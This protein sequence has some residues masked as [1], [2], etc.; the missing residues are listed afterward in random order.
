MLVFPVLGL[1]YAWTDNTTNQEV[2]RL[3]TTVDES[4]PFIKYFSIPYS[5][6]IFY[7]YVCI[8][9]FF[10]KDANVYYRAISTYILCALLCYL[11]YSVFQTTV[12]RPVVMGSD[13]FS[14]LMRYIYHRD[15]PFNCFPSIHCFSS[16]LVMRTI[17]TSSFRNKWNLTIITTMSSTI[18]MSTLFVKQHVIM[19]ALA[20]ILLVEIVTA[21][22][23]LLEQR[24][25][26]IRHERGKGSLG[27]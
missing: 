3:V 26:I 1:M 2:Y 11:I 20:G 10:K 19:D 22:L 6:W 13:P 21:V 24:L 16:Y 25:R 15:Q 4:I 27:A 12:P 5:I 9:Y 7:I 17:W 23:V 8:F 18:I 14:E